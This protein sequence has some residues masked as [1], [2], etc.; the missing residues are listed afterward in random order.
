[1]SS[2]RENDFTTGFVNGVADVKGHGFHVVRVEW[3]SPCN[4]PKITALWLFYK[5]VIDATKHLATR[6][7]NTKHA[8]HGKLYMCGFTTLIWS[9][10]LAKLEC[11]L[12]LQMLEFC[13][14]MM[15]QFM[16]AKVF[17][18]YLWN[19]GNGWTQALAMIHPYTIIHVM[20][21]EWLEL[22]DC[23]VLLEPF[24]AIYEDH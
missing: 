23:T 6:H 2:S 10:I 18:A 15:Y 3:I 20:I 19:T 11:S 13:K 9:I 22:K 5:C 7:Y 8:Q 21:L 1:M 17:D 16:K 14:S 4:L 24:R 12:T